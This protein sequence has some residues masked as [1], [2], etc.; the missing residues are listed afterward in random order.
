MRLETRLRVSPICLSSADFETTQWCFRI[1]SNSFTTMQ[2]LSIYMPPFSRNICQTLNAIYVY[3]CIHIWVCIRIHM[4]IRIHI[5][6]FI[7]KYFWWKKLHIWSKISKPINNKVI[8][9]DQSFKVDLN[10]RPGPPFQE[11]INPMSRPNANKISNKNWN[12]K[13]RNETW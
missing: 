2:S 10:H 8:L 13:M 1:L 11:P 12:P 6:M 3:I 5:Y 4:R 9:S 7:N